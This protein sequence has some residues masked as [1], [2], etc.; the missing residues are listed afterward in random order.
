MDSIHLTSGNHVIVINRKGDDYQLCTGIGG[1]MP[2]NLQGILLTLEQEKY[3]R[4]VIKFVETFFTTKM[5]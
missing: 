2:Y 5:R 4:Y 3:S 1:M